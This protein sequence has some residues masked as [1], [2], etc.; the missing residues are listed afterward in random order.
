MVPKVHMFCGMG[1]GYDLIAFISHSSLKYHI[2]ENVSKLCTYNVQLDNRMQS[3][4]N[5][6]GGKL[7]QDFITIKYPTCLVFFKITPETISDA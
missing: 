4:G 7:N 5:T 3:Y 6:L 1:A 2:H